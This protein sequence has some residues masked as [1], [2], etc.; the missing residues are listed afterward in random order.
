MKTFSQI[1]N[2]NIIKCPIRLNEANVVSW[3]KDFIDKTS[4]FIE[5]W[6]KKGGQ[7]YKV[8]LGKGTIQASKDIKLNII[9]AAKTVKESKI[10]SRCYPK[11]IKFLGSQHDSVRPNAID[12]NDWD[13]ITIQLY[14]YT[15]EVNYDGENYPVAFA[16]I[17]QKK[18]E[19]LENYFTIE[20]FEMSTMIKNPEI[21]NT[22]FESFID[23][24][25][26]SFKGIVVVTQTPG[27]YS[28]FKYHG[29]GFEQEDINDP[30]SAEDK[31][32][33][34]K[35]DKEVTSET[36]LSILKLEF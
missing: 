21:R 36:T 19:L 1:V 10:Y 13:K 11:T 27:D 7:K 2:E 9:E 17:P 8:D 5:V 22:V 4:N 26:K 16:I 12:K 32:N 20:S 31:S 18:I 28:L 29:K 34:E 14:V 3:F 25:K 30:T 24:I 6:K 15:P 23:K 33:K 35:D